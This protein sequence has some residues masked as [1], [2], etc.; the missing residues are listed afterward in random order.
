MFTFEKGEIHAL[1]GENGAGKST[2]MKILMGD[3]R[4]DSGEVIYKGEKIRISNSREAEKLGIC[5]VPQE[6]N[7]VETVDVAENIWL[8][9][10]K[11]F[12]KSGLIDSK[13]RYAATEELFEKIGI[14][15][16]PTDLGNT[17]ST[18][19]KQLLTIA[20]AVSYEADIIIMDEPTSSLTDAE[21]SL[22]FK[23]MRDLSSKGTAIIFISHKLEEIYA[24][25]QRITVMRDGD[26]IGDYATEEITQDQL[27]TQI[28]G[29]EIS[30]Q[31]P[32]KSKQC[33]KTVLQ[34]EHISSRGVFE[35]ISMEVKEGE[36]VGLYGLVGAGRSE[37]MRAVYGIERYMTG[38]VRVEG[39]KIA[40]GKP[41]RSVRRG[42]A[43]V[44]EDRLLT[45]IISMQSVR[46]N[47]SVANLF[48]MINRIGFV[49]EK[50]ER[51][52]VVEMIERLRVK[53]A[54]EEQTIGGL[55]GGNQQKVIL[56]R[57]MLT[58]PKI[59]I[60][61]EPTRGIDV[62]A[63]AEIYQ[64]I[65]ELSGQGLAIVLI[66]SELPEVMGLANRMIVVKDGRFVK[67][68]SDEEMV[69]EDIVNAAFGLAECG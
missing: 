43:M 66:S 64:L 48:R 53:C 50:D 10:E 33:G 12:L 47:L 51:K 44:T 24:I 67:E 58:D 14:Y 8:G 28:A 2:L 30:G 26:F 62:G 49:K 57:W 16:K 34:V 9:R 18:A 23:V 7:I 21:T 42:M 35:D 32:E 65:H 63:K 22:L 69:Q 61:D 29:R 52:K 59:L 36:I 1:I 4:A 41:Y 27:M 15:L 25:C 31:Y 37:I 68:F 38:S 17:L 55:S 13:K 60:L 19:K 6:I 46:S 56:G 39:K 54:T 3:Y 45:G 40:A 20:K 5:M 11:R